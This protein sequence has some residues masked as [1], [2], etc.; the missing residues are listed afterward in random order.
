MQRERERERERETKTLKNEALLSVV[1][2]K[3]NNK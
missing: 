1:I 3:I 2:G